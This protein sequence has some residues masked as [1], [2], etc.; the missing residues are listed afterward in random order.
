MPSAS[1]ISATLSRLGWKST[2]IALVAYVAIRAVVMNYVVPEIRTRQPA[3]VEGRM[4][5]VV[6]VAPF[7][8]GEEAYRIF[9]LY[10]PDIV[11]YVRLFY[12]LDIL[13]PLASAFFWASLIA[14]ML[15][16]LGRTE[17]WSWM[18]LLAFF[19][20]PFDY[21]ENSL[22][23]FMIAQR[24]DV[25]DG[26]ARLGGIATAFKILFIALTLLTFLALA[27]MVL[28]RFIRTRKA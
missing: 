28:A 16:Y 9:G 1:G 24:P 11:G 19:A 4:L 17:R 27:V 5:K 12:A 3:A 25:H 22:A 15:K 6:D 26:L 10:Q 2:L 7:V 14:V 8:S 23:L 18:C 20:L 21:I 13:W